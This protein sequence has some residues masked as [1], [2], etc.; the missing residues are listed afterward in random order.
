MKKPFPHLAAFRIVCTVHLGS[1]SC[2]RHGQGSELVHLHSPVSSI[3][4]GSSH[5]W[6]VDKGN[7]DCNVLSYYSLGDPQGRMNCAGC[8]YYL[9][10]LTERWIVKSSC[11]MVA[12]GR[13]ANSIWETSPH[14]RSKARNYTILLFPGER[15]NKNQTKNQGS[16]NSSQNQSTPQKPKERNPKQGIMS[17]NAGGKRAV[18]QAGQVGVDYPGVL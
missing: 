4:H 9:G 7:A 15:A 14:T 17:I 1:L 16:L 2:C 6:R 13:E 18:L 10:M 5:N 8:G 3:S 12:W 11:Q